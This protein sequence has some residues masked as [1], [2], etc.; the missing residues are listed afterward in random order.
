MDIIW[1]ELLHG[2]QNAIRLMYLSS[3][4]PLC[5]LCGATV[6]LNTIGIRLLR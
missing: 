2:I 6:R 3:T 1:S 5:F 4:P